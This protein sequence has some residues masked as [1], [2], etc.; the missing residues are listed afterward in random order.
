MRKAD[1][2]H[3]PAM[4]EVMNQI[5]YA[6]G[7]GPLARNIQENISPI[8]VERVRPTTDISR[9]ERKRQIVRMA[10]GMSSMTEMSW[11]L[12]AIMSVTS[13]ESTAYHWHS[14]L[15]VIPIYGS[16]FAGSKVTPP[17]HGT[18]QFLKATQATRGP[19]EELGKVEKNFV[20]STTTTAGLLPVPM[21]TSA[22]TRT[23]TRSKGQQLQ[24]PPRQWAK[25]CVTRPMRAA[26]WQ[27]P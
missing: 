2:E 24:A 3:S 5:K 20:L 16:H 19:E 9:Q 26:T 7:H 25:F 10:L 13:V 27:W 23:I 11:Y 4:I 21:R 15:P 22:M 6:F 17:E 18:A 12:E 14:L 1:I 8:T